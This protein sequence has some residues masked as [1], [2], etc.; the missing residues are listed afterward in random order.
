MRSAKKNGLIIFASRWSYIGE[1]WYDEHLQELKVGS[2]LK[3]IEQEDFFKYDRII[4]SI[5]RFSRT[6]SRVFVFENLMDANTA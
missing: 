6:P 2:R 4:S 1:Y 3:F 5:G